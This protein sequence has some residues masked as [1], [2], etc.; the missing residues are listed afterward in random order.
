[1]DE[2]ADLEGLVDVVAGGDEAEG[3]EKEGERGEGCGVEYAEERDTGLAYV[4][5]KDVW[6][7]LESC[8]EM[9]LKPDPSSPKWLH[10]H[11][12]PQM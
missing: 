8:W 5:I 6:G 1:M 11:P 9:R 4:H 2:F 7:M 12:P 10:V 3:C